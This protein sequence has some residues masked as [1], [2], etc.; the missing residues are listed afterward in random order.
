SKEERKLGIEVEH[1][2]LEAKSLQATSYHREKG[3]EDLLRKLAG[4]NWKPKM[5]KGHVVG[6]KGEEAKVTLEP[7]GQLE[8]SIFPQGSI[9]EMKDIYLNFVRQVTLILDDW[10]KKLF[11]LGYQPKSRLNEIS[12]T[13]KERYGYMHD[14]FSE[15]G[16]YAHNM[17]KSTC[18]IHVNL[19]YF[20][21]ED[22]EKKNLVAN[23]LSPIVYTVLDNSPFFEG[24]V[25]EKEGLR[26]LIWDNCDSDRCGYPSRVFTNGFGYRGYAEY[27]LNTPPMVYE[28][29]GKLV[30]SKD[31]LLKDI[32][33]E[34]LN[35]TKE[36]L[37]YVLTT[38]FPDVRTKN[39]LEIRMGD[40]L[41]YPYSFAY[42][43]FWKGLIYSQDNLNNLHK[44]FKGITG[45]QF[46]SRKR[47]LAE[48]GVEANWG[49]IP[50]FQAY[51]D[52][53]ELA[54]EGLDKGEREYLKPL[55]TLAEK[56][57]TPRQKTLKS[58]SEG[59]SNALTWCNLNE[60]IE[61]ER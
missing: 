25:R 59:K 3:I 12:M 61:K 27:L 23:V 57:I 31:K 21:E 47:R 8:L 29:G 34:E 41:P 32:L 16:K 35:P 33:L 30:Y 58:L 49:T 60:I 46:L 28:K 50:I 9:E 40:S 10:G 1:F 52:L 15:R 13:P 45:D 51:R 22:Y 48:K 18:A 6:L 20:N 54:E 14:Y 2:V 39:H 42:I 19:D 37:E 56:D 43:C 11:C 17:M 44:R 36:E 7:G 4:G 38:V 26:R 53:L 24:E 55:K 5:E